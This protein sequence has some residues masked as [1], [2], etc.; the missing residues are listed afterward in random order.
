MQNQT[1]KCYQCNLKIIQKHP[2]LNF[3]PNKRP[4]NNAKTILSGL[5][6]IA[7]ETGMKS[8]VDEY[9]DFIEKLTIR[10]EAAD[11]AFTLY[12]IYG[13]FNHTIPDILQ[14]WKEIC[15]SDDEFAEIKNQWIE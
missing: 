9:Y 14:Q 7:V 2:Y 4:S 3:T 13:S 11:L 6:K 10:Q 1:S 12:S 8:N 5:E 15:K